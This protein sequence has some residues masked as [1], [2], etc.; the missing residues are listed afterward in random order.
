[1]D[2]YFEK[3]VILEGTLWVKGDV[4]FDAS[5]KGDVYS[6][7]HLIIG[8]SG[9]VKGNIHSYNFSSSG[10][11]D[12]DVFSENKT[13]LLK[14]GVLIGDISTYQLVVDE[15]AD[16]G[17]RCKMIN[18]PIDQ[19]GRENKVKKSWKKKNLINLK[20]KKKSIEQLVAK[21]LGVDIANRI[22][23]TKVEEPPKRKG[24]VKVASVAELVSKLKNEAKVI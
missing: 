22:Q 21:D 7:D 18:A 15:G 11:I 8:H 2:S 19:M 1:M 4:H 20:A 10:K 16:F 9:S 17:G 3:G 12:G 5:I 23:Q 24:G 13:S 6:N 14:G